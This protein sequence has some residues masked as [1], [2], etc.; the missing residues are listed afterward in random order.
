MNTGILASNL[1]KETVGE[2]VAKNYHAAGVFR[3]FGID[4]CCGGDISLEEAC[5]KRNVD[6]KKVMHELS[7]IPW[8]QPSADENYQA[9]EP[10]FL[11]D[12]IKNTHHRFVL[13]KTDEILGYAAKVEKVHGQSRPENVEIFHI[14]KDLTKELLRHLEDEET[15]VFPLIEEIY[16]KRLKGQEI[17]VGQIDALQKEL[18]DMVADHEGAGDAMKTIRQL[19]HNFTPPEGACATYRIFYQ[20]LEGFEKDL[21]KHVHLENNILFKKAEKYI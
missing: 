13:S 17:P 10:D 1:E 18:D 9:W 12:H 4:F 21:H 15:R 20:N 7:H 14:F 8:D 5:E 6:T 2:I 19:S 3:H 11:I 16:S